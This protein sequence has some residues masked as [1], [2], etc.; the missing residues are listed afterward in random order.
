MKLDFFSTFSYAVDNSYHPKVTWINNSRYN[1]GKETSLIQTTL[2]PMLW[3]RRRSTAI[4]D[5][6]RT[7][8]RLSI[9]NHWRFISVNNFFYFFGKLTYH[10]CSFTF[11]L[12]LI[13][14][15]AER[16]AFFTLSCHK[17]H[18]FPALYI[19][20]R[21]WWTFTLCN[22]YP[23]TKGLKRFNRPRLKGCC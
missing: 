18:S 1:P 11:P 23:K 15:R 22:C 19:V 5:Y 13:Q 3:S 20:R 12:L 17:P 8:S 4:G 16:L 21:L 10:K 6:K 2:R 14:I 7:V 9:S